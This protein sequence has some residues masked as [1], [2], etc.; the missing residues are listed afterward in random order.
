MII[1]NAVPEDARQIRTITNY[2]KAE[3]SAASGI[4]F[5]EYHSLSLK[6]RRSMM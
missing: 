2:F 6:E 4:G 5:V 3:R 1:R